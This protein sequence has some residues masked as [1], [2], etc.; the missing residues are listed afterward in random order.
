MDT[1]LAYEALAGRTR[2]HGEAIDAFRGK[3]KPSFEGR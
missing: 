1:G 2:D 3:R